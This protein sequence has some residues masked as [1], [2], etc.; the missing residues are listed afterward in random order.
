MIIKVI[1]GCVADD[2]LIDGIS[3]YNMPFYTQT[4]V[5][6]SILKKQKVN[7]VVCTVSS[8]LNF[9]STQI[10]IE[11]DSESEPCEICGD[12]VS[13]TLYKL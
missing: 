7:C 11:S 1:E 3:L 12:T 10:P 13:W 6:K 5:V 8:L 9:L 4:R 2:I